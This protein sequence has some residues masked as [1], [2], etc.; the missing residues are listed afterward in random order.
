MKQL[1][2]PRGTK[3]R[4]PEEQAAW[5][6][7]TGAFERACRLHGFGRIQT[8]TFE[9]HDLFTRGIG[10]ET[11]IV[12]KELYT[13][14]D[15]G[16][17]RLTLR[18]EGTAPVVRA[19]NQHGMKSR[20]QPVRLYYISPF[21]RY[22]R[23][24]AG[25]YREHTQMGTEVLGEADSSVDGEVISLI[26]RVLEDLDLK[27]LSLEINSIGDA[28]CRPEYKDA[29][30]EYY[31]SRVD[32]LCD[33]C[34]Q[35]L[36]R[37]P[38]RLLDCKE[39]HCH[40][41]AQSAPSSVEYLCS[42]CED[43]FQGLREGLDA[44]DIE[45]TVNPR[46]VRGL[47]YYTR[48]VFEIIPAGSGSQGTLAGGGRYDLLSEVIGGPPLPGMGFGS[49]VERIVLNLQDHDGVG[50]ATDRPD[51]FVA[52]LTTAAKPFAGALA[53]N[54]RRM[55]RSAV[56][57][58]REASARSHMRRANASRSRMAI[59]IG[60]RDIGNGT[61]TVRD[62]DAKSQQDVILETAAGEIAALL[63]R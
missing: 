38:L 35:R 2:T 7:V 25:R 21:F 34:K 46:L 37:N 14:D 36:E 17:E 32:E 20:S 15:R 23:P 16:G 39:A 26:W 29:L 45:Y 55:G 1:R 24:Q 5:D 48:T 28:V 18:A 27:G 11:D 8:P 54:L 10:A 58:Y 57:G 12:S 62:M 9:S 4:L 63:D 31:A 52:A 61:V 30:V 59:L 42:D 49:G 60:D 6:R 19:Y 41:L 53:S 43:H 40:E 3:D 47:D 50:D 13:L 51:V 44:L 22:D 56:S 33:D